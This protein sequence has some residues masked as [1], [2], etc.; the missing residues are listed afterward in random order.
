MPLVR[1]LVAVSP[2]DRAGRLDGERAVR[3][4][5]VNGFEV[6]TDSGVDKL[7]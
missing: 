3:Y 4:A 2:M 1:G 6:R 5:G 7:Q